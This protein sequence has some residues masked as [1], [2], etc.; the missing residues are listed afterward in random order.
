MPKAPGPKNQS[1]ESAAL[2][3]RLKQIDGKP[4]TKSEQADIAWMEKQ[5]AAFYAELWAQK[6][7]KG[8]YC[9]LAGRQNKVIDEAAHR[10]GFPIGGP[11]VN[12]YDAVKAL[13]D[14]VATNGQ[15]FAMAMDAENDREE[16]EKEKLR[17]QIE[18][19]TLENETKDINL[20]HARGEAIPKEALRIALSSLQAHLRSFGQQLRRSNPQVVDDYNDFLDRL[21]EEVASGKL[22]FE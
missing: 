12:L 19:L 5:D 10:Y 8:D 1:R 9:R 4:L 18:G 6:C 21:A 7:S 17:K 3:A 15:R 13:H 11:V 16:L 20:Q 14:F 22:A 2:R